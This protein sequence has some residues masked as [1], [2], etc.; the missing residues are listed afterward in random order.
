MSESQAV[1]KAILDKIRQLLVVLYQRSPKKM[2]KNA[3][4]RAIPGSA[5]GDKRA[6]PGSAS[7]DKRAIPGSAA[8][9]RTL[10]INPV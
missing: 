1:K 10:I 2:S 9:R 6:I 8:G 5:A 4:E 7:G 3:V